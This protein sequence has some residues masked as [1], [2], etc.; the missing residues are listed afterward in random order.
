MP[1]FIDYW[2]NSIPDGT[3]EDEP[4]EGGAV[5]GGDVS[6]VNGQTG[7]VVLDAADLASLGALALQDTLV[8]PGDIAATGTP[9][10]STSLHGDGV[11]R[12]P[13]SVARV[14]M[15]TP[16]DP[17]PGDTRWNLYEDPPNLG[18]DVNASDVYAASKAQIVAGTNVTVVANDGLET[19]TINATG[20]T[21]SGGSMFSSLNATAY[22]LSTTGTASANT[23]ALKACINAALG[24]GRNVFI[25][26]G[27]Y[28]VNPGCLTPNLGSFGNGLEIWGEGKYRT[29][30]RMAPQT[31]T[32]YFFDN[33]SNGNT[34]RYV[35]IKDI[36]FE[37]GPTSTGAER[38]N[39]NPNHNGFRLYADNSANDQS[40]KFFR[41]R[42]ATLNGVW[43]SAGSNN[44]SE[45]TF[46]NCKITHIEDYV[47]RVSNFQALNLNSVNSDIEIIWGDIVRTEGTGGGAI[48]FTMGSIII[49]DDGADSGNV[50]KI[51]ADT[52]ATITF[53]GVRIEVRNNAQLV[54]GTSGGLATVNFISCGTFTNALSGPVN[55]VNITS[56]QFVSF[57][58]CTFEHNGSY[59]TYNVQGTGWLVFHYCAVRGSLA[60]EVTTGASATAI[61]VNCRERFN[62]SNIINFTE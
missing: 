24:A 49:Q 10:S 31:T 12:S 25:P 13:T 54:D 41:C 1:R 50:V 53:M 46:D 8:V 62:Q 44:A 60:S 40:F 37:G 39:V 43:F 55:T 19:I 28:I 30:L 51:E 22:G 59:A 36:A 6:S 3:L 27:T 42:F 34:L 26:A 56:N 33:G 32:S 52:T 2:N 9:S 15:T 4:I 61:A 18:G 20:G 14:S 17:Q 5:G 45:I 29:V 57:D 38:A 23:A 58:R 47:W 7:V 48:N 11:W 21:S 16:E 35:T